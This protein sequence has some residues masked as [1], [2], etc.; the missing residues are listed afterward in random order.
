MPLPPNLSKVNGQ[1]YQHATLAPVALSDGGRLPLSAFKSI[2][3]ADGAKKKAVH[4]SQGRRTGGWTLQQQD[5]AEFKLS[6]LMDEWVKFK[7]F[8]AIAYPTLGIGQIVMDWNVSYG[9]TPGTQITDQLYG[10]MFQNDP[11]DSSDSQDALYCELDLFVGGEIID[12]ATGKSFVIYSP[13][14]Q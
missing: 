4:D 14:G 5:E 8:M 1:S 7:K 6:L 12:G 2:K 3:Y 11:R 13:V 10:V 9:N